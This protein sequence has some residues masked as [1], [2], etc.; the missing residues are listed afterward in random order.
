MTG[1][2]YEHY[3]RFYRKHPAWVSLLSKCNKVLTSLGYLLYPFLVAFLAYTKDSRLFSFILVPGIC[4][5]AVSIFRKVFNRP[6]PYED[7]EI[8]AL[9]PREKK[10]ESF[11][12]RH[13]FSFFIISLLYY[14]FCPIFC[15]ALL[16]LGCLLAY[17]RVI[18]GVHYPLDVC[19]G[20][21]LGIFGGIL[22]ILL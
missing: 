18:L 9:K 4:F 13:V 22:T 15:L 2:Q 12:S 17:L 1:Q 7:P 6:R 5:V 10:G 20:A 8:N 19:V 16:I 3:I 11:P 21:L 14:P